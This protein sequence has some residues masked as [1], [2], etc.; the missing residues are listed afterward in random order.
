M[1]TVIVMTEDYMHVNNSSII[2]T[3][4]Y[5]PFLLFILIL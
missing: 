5:A 1:I 3:G 4:H 2:L